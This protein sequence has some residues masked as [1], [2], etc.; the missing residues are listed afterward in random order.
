MSENFSDK[1]PKLPSHIGFAVNKSGDGEKAQW[2][3]IGAMWPTREGGF[4]GTVDNGMVKFDLVLRPREVLDEMREERKQDQAPEH[5]Q[6]MK[7]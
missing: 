6:A 1:A 4:S 3:E 7:V 2:H 5:T